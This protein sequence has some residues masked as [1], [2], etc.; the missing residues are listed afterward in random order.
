MLSVVRQEDTVARLGGDEFTVLIKYPGSVDDAV[1]LANRILEKIVEPYQISH[2]IINISASIGV[3]MSYPRGDQPEDLLRDADY[4]M[5]QAK[6]G[7]KAKI[8]VHHHNS[9]GPQNR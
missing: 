7:G 6:S 2:A 3:V 5:Y 9:E 4:A 8:Y 1:G